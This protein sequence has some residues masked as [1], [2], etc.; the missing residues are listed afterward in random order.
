VVQASSDSKKI[1]GRAKSRLIGRKLG[2]LKISRL[3][4]LSYVDF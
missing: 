1:V 4:A 3:K 2:K